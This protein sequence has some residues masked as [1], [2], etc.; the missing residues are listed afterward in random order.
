M[1]YTHYWRNMKFSKSGWN[2]LK[3]LTKLVI[4]HLPKNVKLAF[5]CD[6]QTKRP[7]ISDELIRFNG[8]GENGHETFYFSKED[9]ENPFNFCKT[10][11]KP[12]DLAVSSVLILASFLCESGV[13]SSDG[14]GKDYTDSEW[15]AAWKFLSELLPQTLSDKQKVFK[16]FEINPEL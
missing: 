4:S 2:E 12:Y 5:E 11:S 14:I 1:G 10:A 9:A 7:V 15:I 6:W 13:I 8:V 3:G 16:A